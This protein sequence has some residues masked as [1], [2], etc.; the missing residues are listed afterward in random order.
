MIYQTYG[1]FLFLLLLLPLPGLSQQVTGS[2]DRDSVSVGDEVRYTVTVPRASGVEKVIYPDS[3]HF[4]QDFDMAGRNTFSGVRSDSAVYHLRYFGGS[5][6]AVP[7]VPVG[8]VS[9]PDT[10]WITVPPTP[11]AFT[12]RIDDEAASLRPFKPLYEFSIFL[13][14]YIIAALF[15]MLLG[16]LG[17]RYYNNREVEESPLAEPDEIPEFHD[18][19]L[20]LER[21]LGFV[22]SEYP[23]PEE[24]FKGYYSSLGNALRSYFEELYDIP[25]L[26]STTSELARELRNKFVND[27]MQSST[28]LL[29]QQADMVKFAKFNPGRDECIKAMQEANNFLIEARRIDGPRVRSMKL[30]HDE[31]IR[32]INEQEEEMAEK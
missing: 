14:P 20:A 11:M 16:W 22:K 26:E 5:E 4:E 10:L 31:F 32:K 9:G 1:Y 28:N 17:W 13:L 7:E 19:L 8:L 30:R 18:P 29:L 2:V 27:K 21:D 6:A 23:H 12:S 15:L 24:D 25:A 3:S